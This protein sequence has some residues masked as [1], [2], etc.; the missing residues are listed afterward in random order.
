MA[1]FH[2][3]PREERMT[4]ALRGTA[5]YTQQVSHITED[6][7][8]EETNLEGWTRAHI[9]SHVSYNAAALCN[10]VEW[11]T[12][13]VETPMY[14]SPTARNEEIE[15]GTTLP[16]AALF[17]LH[18][19]TVAR[20]TA[21]W[22]SMDDAAWGHQ[23][24]TAQGRTVP[25][26]EMLWMRSREVWIHAFDLNKGATFEQIPTIILQT[27]IPEILAKWGDQ[28]DFTLIDTDSG[29]RYG[30]G[31]TEIRGSLAGLARWASGRGS[32]GVDTDLEPPRWL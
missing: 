15:Y 5:H 4:L 29:E 8:G 17:N 12:T 30:N 24:R 27:L 11:A 22:N 3:L 19:H 18:D 21:A 2:D 13:G 1:S 7:L 16:P 26:E 25:A 20:L 28:A 10:L 14:S 31:S 23:V 9:I 32:A 6:E